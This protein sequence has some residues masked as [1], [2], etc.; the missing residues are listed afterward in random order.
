MECKTDTRVC[1]VG[2]NAHGAVELP[3]GEVSAATESEQEGE[4]KVISFKELSDTVREQQ[5][6]L[7]SVE[8]DIKFPTTLTVTIERKVQEKEDEEESETEEEVNSETGAE[9]EAQ[10]GDETEKDAGSKTEDQDKAENGSDTEKDSDQ[11]DENKN[12]SEE[13][14]GKDKSESEETSGSATESDSK[15]EDKSND[16]DKSGNEDKS[17]SSD[18]SDSKDDSEESPESDEEADAGSILGEIADVLLPKPM[19]VHAAEIDD[20]KAGT[21][22]T[23]SDTDSSDNTTTVTTTEK[24]TLK[25]IRWELDEENSAYPEFN[26]GIAPEDYFEEFDEDGEPVETDDKTWDGYYEANEE[27]NGAFYT[28]VPVLPETVALTDDEGE[29]QDYALKLDEDVYLPEIYVLVGESGIALYATGNTLDISELT[30]SEKL[31][32]GSSSRKESEYGIIRIDSDNIDDFNNKTLTGEVV[33]VHGGDFARGLIIDG[34]TLNLTIEDLT[35]DRS[36]GY[37]GFSADYYGF[38]AIA[39]E[40]GAKLNLTLEGDNTLKGYGDGGVGICV[41]A[42]TTL[43]IDGEGSLEAVGGNGCGGAA[44]IGAYASGWNLNGNNG[45]PRSV[46]NIII[47][48]GTIT[49]Q[50]GT[51]YA[52]GSAAMGAAGIGGGFNG[53]VQSINISG[54]EVTATADGGAAIGT[55]K[56]TS[57]DGTKLS[58][59]DISITGG[60]V[61]ANGNIGYAE[62]DK[63][64]GGS[65]TISD[66][67]YLKVT[68]EIK[69]D[70]AESATAKY[71]LNFSVFDV[72]FEKDME[73]DAKVELDSNVIEK[74][75]AAKVETPGKAEFTVDFV[76]KKFTAGDETFTI[77]INNKQYMGTVT[78]SDGETEWSTAVC[79]RLRCTG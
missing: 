42:G 45:T 16:E 21:T 46:G 65:V 52:Y 48:G 12:G 28:Y 8:E 66:D 13:K 44:G 4:A 26:G 24:I 75:V 55:G 38:S 76:S 30:L 35:I 10:D 41:N 1:V 73:A 39:L 71:T 59:G 56:N 31:I 11:E 53:S 3:A 14:S 19:I 5:L 9:T 63:Y 25:N 34:V 54:G 70:A 69:T 51:M 58:C 40:N 36:A 62:G 2:G 27:V 64:A 20:T 78:F 33:S 18:D 61:I 7:G 23:A 72:D 68:G 50:G 29:E 17:D 22:K 47:K 15:D 77:T 79:R 43:T 57:T 74:A 37:N 67:V 32:N 60:S 49:A 6:P